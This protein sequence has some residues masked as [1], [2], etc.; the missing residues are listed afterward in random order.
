MSNWT[1]RR[2]GLKLRSWNR[3]C[4]IGSWARTRLSNEPPVTTI[5]RCFS[6]LGRQLFPFVPKTVQLW[7]TA[8]L[9]SFRRRPPPALFLLEVL[10]KLPFAPVLHDTFFS[11]A[12]SRNFEP[13]RLFQKARTTDPHRGHVQYASTPGR[14]CVLAM[15]RNHR[16]LYRCGD[17]FQGHRV[18]DGARTIRKDLSSRR[19]TFFS[20]LIRVPSRQL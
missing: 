6:D 14:A 12:R 1:S 19:E 2:Q 10:T 16:R 4:A 18:F 13:W 8:H 17:S 11:C 5:R 3:I 9:K 20:R 7:R 15:D